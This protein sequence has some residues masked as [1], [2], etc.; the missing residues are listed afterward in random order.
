MSF[1]SIHKP[2]S[3]CGSSDGLS[4]NDDFSTYCFACA[5]FTPSDQSIYTE[6]S[7]PPE[8]IIVK[9]MTSFLESYN[10]GVST[11]ISDRKLSKDTVLIEIIAVCV[12]SIPSTC[13]TN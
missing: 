2:C 1:I 10:N 9:D 13:P 4:I 11:S 8:T 5:N 12:L 6:T 7:M 3:D